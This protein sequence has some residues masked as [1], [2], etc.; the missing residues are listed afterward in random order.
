MWTRKA[1]EGGDADA[2]WNLASCLGEE[3]ANADWRR[4]AI[5]WSLKAA[6][7]G[8]KR[9]VEWVKRWEQTNPEGLEWARRVLLSAPATNSVPGSFVQP[10]FR[11]D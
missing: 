4:E 9:A 5:V 2:Q 3:S 11:E 1:A 8:Q 7:A 6:E 10:A